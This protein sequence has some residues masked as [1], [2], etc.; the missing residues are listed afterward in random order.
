MERRKRGNTKLKII[1]TALNLFLQNGYSN[2]YIPEIAQ[3]VGLSKGNL[4]FH[5]HTKE[6]LL[7]ELINMLCDFQWEVMER[8]VEEGRSS[9][10][11]YLLELVTIASVCEENAVAKDLYISAYI[12]PMVLGIIRRNDTRKTRKVFEEYC[13]G[14]KEADFIQAENVVSGI[15]YA[16]L[17]EENAEKLF[18]EQRI[19]GSLD[20]IMKIYDLSKELRESMIEKV[21]SMDYQNI[22]NR[23]LSEFA[24]YVDE[25]SKS[26]LLKVSQ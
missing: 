7:A 2:T 21:L 20:A 15:E 13:A 24:T 5:F 1:D 10:L 16:M 11:A 17:V 19:A 23:I 3:K 4:M 25:K 6:H 26:E 22:G 18:F 14:W 9:L 12:H 8:E